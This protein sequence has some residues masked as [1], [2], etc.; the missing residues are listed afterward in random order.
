MLEFLSDH[1]WLVWVVAVLVA[2]FLF[3]VF[4]SS[5]FIEADKIGLVRKRFGKPLDGNSVVA[6]NGEAGYQAELL[7]PGYRFRLWPLYTVSQEPI[8][9]I[10]AGEIGIVIAQVG[11]P[12]P[13]GAKSAVYKPEF[14]DFSDLATFIEKGGQQGVQRPPLLPGTVAAIHPVAFLVRTKS[15]VYGRSISTDTHDLVQLVPAEEL[16][17]KVIEAERG[18]KKDVCGIV[19][20]FE[21]Q[22][23]DNG[24]IASRIDGFEDVKALEQREGTTDAELAE[25]VFKSK[26]AIHNAYQDFQAF[27]DAGGRIGLQHDPV[28]YG[29]YAWNPYLVKCEKVE[30][31]EIEQG[32]VG[33]VKAF[34]GLPTADISGESFKHGAIVRPGHRGLWQEPLRTNKY[35]LNRRLYEVVKVHTKL[36]TLNWADYSSTA[37][38]LD[39]DLQPIEAK[40]KEGFKFKIDL[41]V[42][43]HIPDAKAPR[44]IS[45]VGSVENLVKELLQGAVGNHFRN[46]LQSMAAVDFI[47]SRDEVQ[48]KAEEHVRKL[49]EK[50][51]VE[52]QG[53]YIQ[54]VELPKELTDVLQQKEIANQSKAMFETKKAMEEKRA[55]ME[56]AAARAAAMKSLVE[57]EVG[58]SIAASH[59]DAKK[60]TAE[61]EAYY[62]RETGK[63]KGEALEAEGVGIAKG[64]EAQRAAIGEE[65]TAKVNM[66]RALADS[67]QPIV[68]VVSSGGGGNLVDGILGLTL[69]D[70]LVT[71]T[72]SAID[73]PQKA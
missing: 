57:A 16:V 47:T 8:V 61:G 15:K 64:F 68:S 19:T 6:F 72:T 1:Q 48:R 32:E 24:D 22:P 60:K 26:N 13:N 7:R 37:H 56:E 34:I 70:K 44:V 27:L 66:I 18:S 55:E 28:P 41:Q 63:A 23:A 69:K 11:A 39:K 53:V 59:A 30:M 67:K 49:L 38:T 20:T 65:A 54:S 31:L 17:V 58:V 62:T 50:Y 10:P 25:T 33:V 46:T 51:E 35:A 14:G 52:T 21:G 71:Q 5:Y 4:M 12:K 43:I 3:V 9:Q 40:S 29:A 2:V 42:Q 73:A 36:L 45:R